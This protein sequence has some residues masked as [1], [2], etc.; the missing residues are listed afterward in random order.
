MPTFTIISCVNQLLRIGAKP[1]FVDSDPT[2]WNMKVEDVKRKITRKTKLI[3]IV[4]IYGL[5]VN[6]DPILKV[7]K[8]HKIKVLE[9]AAEVIGQE[10]KG[11]KCG[12]FG[13]ISTFSFY[14][15]KH[16]TTG[17]GGN[18]SN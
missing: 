15:N 4:H 5:T 18:D 3:M 2:T 6:L 14:P 11:R 9:D 12:S 16:I 10:Y 13:D 8:S 7:A 17:E 1:I